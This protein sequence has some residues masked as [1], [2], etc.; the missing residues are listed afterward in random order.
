MFSG[1][2]YLIWKK[3]GSSGLM[4]NCF[5]NDTFSLEEN[6]ELLPSFDLGD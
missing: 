3:L 6:L 1:V 5:F 4:N 2:R